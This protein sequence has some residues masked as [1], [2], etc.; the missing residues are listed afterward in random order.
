MRRKIVRITHRT[1]GLPIAEGP[2]G[3]GIMPFEG[4]FYI[5]RSFSRRQVWL[6]RTTK[7]AT[8]TRTA[9]RF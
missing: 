3:W 5:R 1:T 4:N 9:S 2:I 6:Y 7:S 8:A